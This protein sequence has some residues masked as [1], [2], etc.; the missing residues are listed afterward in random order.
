MPVEADF[1]FPLGVLDYVR[2]NITSRF[3]TRHGD[4][5][6]GEMEVEIGV[7]RIG[8]TRIKGYKL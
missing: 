4:F 8:K 1:D 6:I 5:I 3:R 7:D 2:R